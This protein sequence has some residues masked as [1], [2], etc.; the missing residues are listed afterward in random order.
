MARTHRI[1]SPSPLQPGAEVTLDEQGTRHLVQVLRLKSGDACVLFDGSGRDFSATLTQAGKRGCRARV[2]NILREEPPATLQLHLVIGISR[3]ERMD[4][5]IQKAVELGISGITPVF[6]ERSMVNLSGERLRNRF[7]HWQGVIR[8]AC[9]QSGR[10]RL[11][12]LHAPQ[13]LTDWLRNFAGKGLMLD[14]RAETTLVSQ[15]RPDQDLTLLVG[16]EGGLSGNERQLAQ[17][18]RM[19][20]VRLGPRILRTET[21]PLA[22]LA[23]AQALWGDFR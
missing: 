23:V 21:A 20:G 14:H 6:T 7:E 22:A 19:Q 18:N 9:E 1:F 5:S 16:P 11:A 8:H 12:E 13:A 15:P 10:S 4:F 17:R 3:G 2:G